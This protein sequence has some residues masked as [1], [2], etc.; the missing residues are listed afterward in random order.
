[1]EY[2]SMVINVSQWHVNISLLDDY[3]D[4]LYEI[5]LQFGIVDV[6]RDNVI[7]Q[8][9]NTVK[10][11]IPSK[12]RKVVYS[13]EF[14]C[15]KEYERALDEFVNRIETGQNIHP[16]MSDKILKSSY[17]DLLL[18]DWNIHHFHLTRR[19][20]KDGFAKRNDYE[21]FAYVT[22]NVFYMI[23]IYPHDDEVL[24]SKQEMIRIIR[25]NWPELIKSYHM[26]GVD[27]LTQKLDDYVYKKIREAN[28]STL[29]ELGQNQV[30]GMIGGG[31]ASNGY[32]MEALQNVC[33]WERR[34]NTF[35][36][37]VVENTEVIL[38]LIHEN[39]DVFSGSNIDIKM[40]WVDNPYK[41]TL[42]ERISNLI[43][44]VDIKDGIIRICQPYEV[45]WDDKPWKTRM[46]NRCL[47]P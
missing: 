8:Y 27:S 32:S 35:Q 45:F 20:R 18:N 39:Y 17:N 44:Q 21:I 30:Y 28:I 25:N 37:I 4:I 9:W 5:L 1:M 19:F 29:V 41:V 38:R 42:L 31:Y 23:Q 3:K 14:R 11:I 33:F 12:P 40:L 34:M 7:F 46:G 6:D 10:R 47:L 22:N 15:P 2:K 43:I 24:Y 36:K 26:C 13:A 16:F